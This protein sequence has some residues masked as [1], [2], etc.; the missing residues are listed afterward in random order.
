MGD[1]IDEVPGGQQRG[2]LE[3]DHCDSITQPRDELDR[4]QRTNRALRRAVKETEERDL[5]AARSA[6]W[7]NIGNEVH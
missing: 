1:T 3:N 7:R 6:F 2:G 4:A 5:R